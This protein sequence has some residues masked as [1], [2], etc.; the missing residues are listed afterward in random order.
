[1][2]YKILGERLM[3]DKKWENI[4]LPQSARTSKSDNWCSYKFGKEAGDYADYTFSHK[5]V[6]VTSYDHKDKTNDVTIP[7]DKIVFNSTVNSFKIRK[8]RVEFTLAKADFKELASKLMAGEIAKATG[9]DVVEEKSAA[10][11]ETSTEKTY[12]IDEANAIIEKYT[13][14]YYAL[15]QPFE[16]DIVSDDDGKQI[17]RSTFNGKYLI[18]N[19]GDCYLGDD[20]ELL[21]TDAFIEKKAKLLKEDKEIFF[22]D[23]CEAEI[24]LFGGKS[25]TLE[26]LSEE[27]QT[28]IK[29]QYKAY[30]DDIK[31]KEGNY[32]DVQSL[33]DY[34][35]DYLRKKQ[36]A[37]WENYSNAKLYEKAMP[38]VLRNNK[39]FVNWRLD[40]Y[41]KDGQPRPKPAKIPV[42]PATNRN[43]L[44]S[45][46]TT[47]GTFEEACKNADN[48]NCGIGYVFDNKGLVGIDLDGCIENGKVND[49][50][51]D[52]VKK[53]NSYTEISPS[54]TGLHIFTFGKIESNINNRNFG[55][56]MYC[57]EH[58]VIFTGNHL[59]GTPSAI[60]KT[61]DAQPVIT[62]LYNQYKPQ[63][64]AQPVIN[65]VGSPD[66][67]TATT[68][69]IIER[70]KASK[71]YQNKYLRFAQGK[72]A[73][74]EDEN[75]K[76]VVDTYY[77]K[78][79]GTPDL[80]KIDSAFVKAIAFFKATPEQI[81][82][83]YR[84]QSQK[85]KVEGITLDDASLARDKWDR[86]SNGKT[87]GQYV[88]ERAY[89]GISS[90][91]G[92]NSKWASYNKKRTSKK[93]SENFNEG[94]E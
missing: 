64:V 10:Q 86:V 80:S 73:L 3:A 21:L 62:E 4:L 17:L 72:P 54:G 34:T 60:A 26:N 38:Y 89:A 67:Q 55:I 40:Y 42:N 92:D 88:I 81:D 23:L 5:T 52:I 90:T 82:E 49:W 39:N 24:V 37:K 31:E 8:G 75:G 18:V 12:S 46:H 69:E 43:A 77:V 59:K 66:K 91:W 7:V 84:C 50:A 20:M 41:D 2:P 14:D 35:K 57:K 33:D 65:A 16:E 83:I 93:D 25:N 87:Y 30:C 1:M 68:F 47:W 78:E 56:E 94:G 29:T 53:V 9:K 32:S 44:A 63:S 22:D 27:E 76:L 15:N 85:H 79:D 11:A 36:W 74:I 70:L 51:M 19:D 48:G 71:H 28:A 45:N 58:F 6:L 61:I 13:D